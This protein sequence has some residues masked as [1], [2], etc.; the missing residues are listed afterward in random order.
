MTHGIPKVT[1]IF[2]T[3]HLNSRKKNYNPPFAKRPSRKDDKIGLSRN[4]C[5]SL[6]SVLY[7]KRLLWVVFFCSIVIIHYPFLRCTKDEY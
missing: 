7:F 6:S 2:D 5:A 1:R 4:I 3:L